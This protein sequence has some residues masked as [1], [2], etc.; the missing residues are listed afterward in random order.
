MDTANVCIKVLEPSEEDEVV[1]VSAKKQKENLV[2]K[3]KKFKKNN[4]G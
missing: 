4:G 2:E 1:E 3:Y